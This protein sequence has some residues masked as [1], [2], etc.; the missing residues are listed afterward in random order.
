[1]SDSSAQLKLYR[2][3]CNLAAPS[4]S[5]PTRL[6]SGIDLHC[7]ILVPEVD[8]AL[9]QRPELKAIQATAVQLT[10]SDSAAH[11][12]KVM[13]TVLPK[14]LDIE[15]R[16]ADMDA[17]GVEIQVLS[18]SP[19]QYYYWLDEATAETIVARQNDR[20]AEICAARPERFLALAAVALQHP[21]LAA[22]Q[23]EAAMA[24]GFKG[25]EI[26]TYIAGRELSDPDFD[27][28]WQ[29][30]ESSGA[31][32]SRSGGKGPR[33][34]RSTRG[35]Q[36]CAEIWA[37]TAALS[38]VWNRWKAPVSRA[39][40]WPWRSLIRVRCAFMRS[41]RAARRAS[42]SAARILPWPWS[43]ASASA[44]IGTPAAATSALAWAFRAAMRWSM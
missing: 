20:L 9:A 32:T 26:S 27:P 38:W 11:N 43:R 16:L 28:F 1:M 3:G 19:T 24:R 15:V 21:Y 34:L 25:A 10:G 40:I 44:W 12:M 37:S 29:A 18:P 6:K 5:E 39:R 41:R 14:L 22:R 2:C 31:V 17:L 7:H 23:L 30:A 8:A 35:S 4:A 36:W 42:Y 13:Q 33:A